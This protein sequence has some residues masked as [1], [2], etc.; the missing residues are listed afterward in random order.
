VLRAV[1]RYLGALEYP[2]TTN[3]GWHHGQLLVHDSVS[4]HQEIK[5]PMVCGLAV[6]EEHSASPAIGENFEG[7]DH[8]LF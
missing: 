7:I 4:G 3:I 2:A 8:S 5:R 1:E 6:G